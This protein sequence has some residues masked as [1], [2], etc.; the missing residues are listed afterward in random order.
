MD[1]GTLSGI[2]TVLFLILF[3]LIVVWAYSRKNKADFDAAAQLPFEEDA[4]D[5]R[6]D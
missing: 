5:P 4:T 2:I 6:R 1:S 3:G